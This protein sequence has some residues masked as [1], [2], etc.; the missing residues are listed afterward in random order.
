MS[1]FVIIN[2]VS[3]VLQCC[4]RQ[5]K[6]FV[7][8]FSVFGQLLPALVQHWVNICKDRNFDARKEI[9]TAPFLSSPSWEKKNI[10]TAQKTKAEP[11]KFIAWKDKVH[12]NR[13]SLSSQSLHLDAYIREQD[14][15]RKRTINGQFTLFLFLELSFAWLLHVSRVIWAEHIQPIWHTVYKVG[16]REKS[17]YSIW[18]TSTSILSSNDNHCSQISCTYFHEVSAISIWCIWG[19][20]RTDAI[21]HGFAHQ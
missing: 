8:C 10:E 2:V 4:S 15:G 7:Y 11:T 19:S 17:R 14:K 6:A 5:V 20:Y 1:M 16:S 21:T 12:W 18:D 13:N 3:H 9:I